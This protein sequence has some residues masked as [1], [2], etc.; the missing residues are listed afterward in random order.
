VPLASSSCPSG[1][2]SSES[3]PWIGLEQWLKEGGQLGS[4]PPA[5]VA[6]TE[7]DAGRKRITNGCKVYYSMRKGDKVHFTLLRD[8]TDSSFHVNWD[9]TGA[10]PVVLLAWKTHGTPY[11]DVGGRGQRYDERIQDLLLNDDIDYKTKRKTTM[12]TGNFDFFHCGATCSGYW[13]AGHNDEDLYITLDTQFT[14]GAQTQFK[15]WYQFT[16]YENKGKMNSDQFKA[17]YDMFVKVCQPYRN[18]TA[19]PAGEWGGTMTLR[20]YLIT[21]P[22]DPDEMPYCWWQRKGMDKTAMEGTLTQTGIAGTCA[23]ID[24]IP[25]DDGGNV[26]DVLLVGYGLRGPIPQ[27][28]LAALNKA[29]KIHLG[30]NRLSGPIPNSFEQHTHLIELDLNHNMLNGKIPCFGGDPLLDLI[31][32]FNLFD[33]TVPTCLGDISKL[34]HLKLTGNSLTGGIPTELS[35]LPNLATL[36]LNKNMLTGNIPDIICRS[37]SPLELLDVSMNRL[38]G[39]LNNKCLENLLRLKVFDVAYNQFTGSLPVVKADLKRLLEIDLS[40]NFLVGEFKN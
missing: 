1:H 34:E 22:A 9:A 5:K 25:C 4:T 10:A 26:A 21:H 16:F 28:D 24:N 17:I 8:I 13:A 3:D 23:Q 36:A 20:S 6:S 30:Q 2:G 38:S 14:G 18:N 32:S 27:A 35:K 7:E 33:G 31:L 29:T 12:G 15:G 11:V 40:H 37:T 19:T 39:P